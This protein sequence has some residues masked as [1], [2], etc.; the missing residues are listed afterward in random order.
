MRIGILTFHAAHN[1]G[2]VLQCYALQTFLQQEGHDVE[3]IDYRIPSMLTVYRVWQWRRLLRNLV[4]ELKLLPARRARYAAFESFIKTHLAL[5]P[6]A[7]VCQRPFDVIIV[8]SDQVWNTRLTKGYSPY[9]WGSFQRPETTRLISYAASMQDTWPATENEHIACLLRSFAAL[10]V[11]EQTLADRLRPLLPGKEVAVVADPT[12]LLSREQWDKVAIPP[13]EDTPYLLLYQV[14]SNPKVME[15]AHAVAADLGL[16]VVC[17][18]ARVDDENS[19]GVEATSPGAFVGLFKYASFVVCSSFHGTVF[20]LLYARPFFSVRMNT[21]K[22]N[23][24]LCLLKEFGL[25]DLF[26]DSYS[27]D[28]ALKSRTPYAV[29]VHESD[30]VRASRSFLHTALSISS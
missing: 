9:Y 22:D 12:L 10:S 15:M 25:E 3:V 4:A 1:Y 13:P 5:T 17:L 23:R 24:V 20:S 2:A 30:L 14:E 16:R 19:A 27:S 11:R 21:G 29:S 26:I 18:S 7:S 28:D 6:V 8:G